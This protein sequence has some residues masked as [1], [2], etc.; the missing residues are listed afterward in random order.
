MGTGTGMKPNMGIHKGKLNQ[1]KHETENHKTRQVTGI[2]MSSLH[3]QMYSLAA[4]V[5]SVT[6]GTS[7]NISSHLQ[8]TQPAVNWN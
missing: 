3:F 1:G 5:R 8:Q 6:T 4:A 2:T 7:I